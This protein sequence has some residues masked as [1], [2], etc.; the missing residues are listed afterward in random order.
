MAELARQMTEAARLMTALARSMEE[1]HAV[2]L[3][4]VR[5]S[6]F[7]KRSNNVL[8]TFYKL[9]AT[10]CNGLRLTAHKEYSKQEARKAC[11]RIAMS[12]RWCA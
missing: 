12:R 1:W 4:L 2:K 6:A 8:K 7:H 11:T 3:M 9:L 10:H 5:V